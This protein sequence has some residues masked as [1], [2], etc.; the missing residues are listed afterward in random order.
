MNASQWTIPNTGPGIALT[1]FPGK[2]SDPVRRLSIDPSI[3]EDADLIL[4]MCA[5]F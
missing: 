3:L 2:F 5:P 4:S 1:V